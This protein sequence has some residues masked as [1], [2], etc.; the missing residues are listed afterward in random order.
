M[1]HLWSS[2]SSTTVRIQEGRPRREKFIETAS[3]WVGTEEKG[4]WLKDMRG[5]LAMVATVVA[6][7]T[8]QVGLNPPGGVVQN[9][10][11]GLCDCAIELQ[12]YFACP[13]ESVFAAADERNFFYF[14]LSNNISF[15]SSL[16][17]CLWLMSGL[18]IYH[19]FPT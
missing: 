4:E 11:N 2:P 18:P 13:G 9:E 15:F 19:R 1:G 8:F 16:M 12:E 17:V 7:M 5:N 6:T 3:K 14:M 10:K